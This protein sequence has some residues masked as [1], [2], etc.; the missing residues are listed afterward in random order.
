MFTE[1]RELGA[2]VTQAF[3]L[4]WVIFLLLSIDTSADCQGRIGPAHMSTVAEAFP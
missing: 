1:A 4:R 3:F 2:G